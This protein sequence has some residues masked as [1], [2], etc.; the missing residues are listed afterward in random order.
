M[1]R[2]SE[3]QRSILSCYSG[4]REEVMTE[5]RRA[6][7]FIEDVELRE[8]SAELLMQMESMSDDKIMVKRNE[9][10]MDGCLRR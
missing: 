5:L 9:G 6:I 8:M 4:T 1:I 2:L 7:P 3:E 10:M